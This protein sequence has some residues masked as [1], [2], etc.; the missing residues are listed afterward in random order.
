MFVDQ[1]QV[2]DGKTA[3]ILCSGVIKS[4]LINYARPLIYTTFMSFPSLLSI[5]V[6]YDWLQQGKTN[7]V[8]IER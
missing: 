3:A 4:Y 2:A 6:T 5:K 1:D 7:Q 8:S